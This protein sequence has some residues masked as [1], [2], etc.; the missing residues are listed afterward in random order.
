MKYQLPRTLCLAMVIKLNDKLQVKTMDLVIKIFN[1]LAIDEL[2][3]LQ[4]YD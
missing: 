2:Y 1:E 3:E 4:V